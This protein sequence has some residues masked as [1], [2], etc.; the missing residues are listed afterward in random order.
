MENGIDILKKIKESGDSTKVIIY[1]HYP[2]PQ[3]K[4]K[5]SHFGADYFFD[6]YND[7]D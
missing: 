4:R 5:C 1:A 2:F 3:Y 7:F 6:K